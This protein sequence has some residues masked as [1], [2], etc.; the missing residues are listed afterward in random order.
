MSEEIMKEYQRRS[1]LAILLN[2]YP[3]EYQTL[4][5]SF[6]LSTSRVEDLKI[7]LNRLEALHI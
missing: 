7:I 6:D 1:T 5:K 3:E 4:N 2:N